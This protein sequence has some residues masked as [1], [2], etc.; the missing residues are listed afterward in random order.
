MK[1]EISSQDEG[2]SYREIFLDM[3]ALSDVQSLGYIKKT[4]KALK[5]PQTSFLRLLFL[6]LSDVVFSLTFY[7]KPLMT[8]QNIWIY[9]EIKLNK[10]WLPLLIIIIIIIR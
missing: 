4:P 8:S 7:N 9:T 6:N 10:C 5:F 1:T 2:V 3:K